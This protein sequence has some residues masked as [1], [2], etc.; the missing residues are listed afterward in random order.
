M[1]LDRLSMVPA[2]ATLKAAY[3]TLAG[4]QEFP[5]PM[6]AM[7]AAVLFHELCAVLRVDPSE[8]LDKARRVTRHAEDHYSLELR[9]LRTYIKEELN[10]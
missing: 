9:A 4:A 5:A 8:M 2:H 7:G 6:Q 1:N 10:K 3:S